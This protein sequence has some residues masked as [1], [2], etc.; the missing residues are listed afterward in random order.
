MTGK[1]T[2][3]YVTFVTPET[4]KHE[5]IVIHAIANTMPSSSSRE[6]GSAAPK[7]GDPAQKSPKAQ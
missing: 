1:V 4:P 3:C 7:R 2:R 5:R 6:R